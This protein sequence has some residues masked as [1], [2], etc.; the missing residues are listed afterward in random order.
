M[1][2]L[3]VCNVLTTVMF[4]SWAWLGAAETWTDSDLPDTVNSSHLMLKSL[5]DFLMFLAM[6]VARGL[7]LPAVDSSLHYNSIMQNM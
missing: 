5:M 6:M 1:I 7:L 4:L 3:K 2:V